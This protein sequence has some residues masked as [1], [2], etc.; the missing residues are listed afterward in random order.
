MNPTLTAKHEEFLVRHPDSKPIQPAGDDLFDHYT[1]PVA[2]EAL[3]QTAQY[4][5]CQFPVHLECVVAEWAGDLTPGKQA[6]L[7]EALRAD[8]EVTETTI[9][10]VVAF[11]YLSVPDSGCG[12]VVTYIFVDELWVTLFNQVS[13]DDRIDGG[14]LRDVLEPIQTLNPSRDIFNGI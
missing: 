9:G 1:G 13:K 2:H 4:T 8:P 5:G 12:A 7:I 11:Q 6:P 10:D 3:A 14:Q